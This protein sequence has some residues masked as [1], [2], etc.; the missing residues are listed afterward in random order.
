ML[1]PHHVGISCPLIISH[2]CLCNNIAD[3]PLSLHRHGTD[4]AA[5][6]TT[7]LRVDL[8]RVCAAESLPGSARRD[9]ALLR[10]D[11]ETS[12]GDVT[13]L[14]NSATEAAMLRPLHRQAG[15]RDE[16]P[17]PYFAWQPV[18]GAILLQH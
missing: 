5:V 1:F 8:G 2:V 17:A 14:G 7:A 12:S 6:S 13:R 16:E 4:H 10:A 18:A 3:M 9:D 15:G 11:D